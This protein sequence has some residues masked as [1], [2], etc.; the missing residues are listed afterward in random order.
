M[1]CKYILQKLL[2][3]IFIP[4][5]Q[6]GYSANSSTYDQEVTTT[7]TLKGESNQKKNIMVRGICKT[8]PFNGKKIIK[9]IIFN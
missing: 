7:I 4:I 2:L 8:V 1:P 9:S 5:V 3:A 6:G